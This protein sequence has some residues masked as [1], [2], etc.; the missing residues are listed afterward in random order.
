MVVLRSSSCFE[1]SYCLLSVA[2]HVMEFQINRILAYDDSF[3]AAFNNEL[4]THA[5]YLT[6]PVSLHHNQWNANYP[7]T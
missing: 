1:V 3:R 4:L 5:S 6:L 2:E 7:S